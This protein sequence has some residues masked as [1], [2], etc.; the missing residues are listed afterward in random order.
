MRIGQ[1]EPY[2]DCIGTIEYDP[3]KK[4]HFGKL[5][6]IDETVTYCGNSIVDLD[7][8][9]HKAVD[10]YVNNKTGIGWICPRCGRVHAPWVDT[11]NCI[12]TMTTT[13]MN[14]CDHEWYPLS[15][16]THGV[17]YE[18]SK[19]GLTKTESYDPDCSGTIITN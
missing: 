12:V 14:F 19:C 2:K 16:G 8:S 6:D 10:A 11:C 1:F 17:K 18:C 5:L 4:E 7:E 3:Q 15:I 9:Y 13:T